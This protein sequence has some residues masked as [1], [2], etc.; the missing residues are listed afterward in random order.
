MTAALLPSCAP[1]GPS[2]AL[3]ATAA[4]RTAGRANTFVRA[5]SQWLARGLAHSA[6]R[7]AVDIVL[8]AHDR[9]HE[10]WVLLI[11]QVD[12]DLGGDAAN[13][14][15]LLYALLGRIAGSLAQGA[16]ELLCPEVAAEFRD[17]LAQRL[18]DRTEGV[19]EH[20]WQAAAQA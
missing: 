8:G 11:H 5:Q 1:I 16:T 4:A 13:E 9:S 10:R 7:V 19:V 14:V 15:A 18:A 3:E 2:G 17:L 20:L 6:D 12:N